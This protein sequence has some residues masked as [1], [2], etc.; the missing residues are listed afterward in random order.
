MRR[1]KREAGRGKRSG[2]RDGSVI[3]RTLACTLILLATTASSSAAQGA[4]KGAAKTAAASGCAINPGDAWVK[5][6]AEWLDESKHDWKDDTLRTALLAA[7]G[8]TAPLEAPVQVGV[9]IE[10]RGPQLGSTADEMTTR[11]KSIAAVR[12]SAWPGKALVGAAGM[13]AVFLLAQRDSGLARAALHRMM[14][15][16][17]DESL[18]ADVSTLEDQFRLAQQGRK[19]IVGT[20]FSIDASGAVVLSPMEDSAHAD[21]RREGSGLPP[22]RLGL[23]LAKQMK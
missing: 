7:A 6:Q 5:R 22:F 10:G 1:G 3:A 20:Q 16:G 23:C 14:E 12:G 19:Q 15:A 21:M 11:L 4:K 18:A 17:P 8:L 9:H 2:P 13:H